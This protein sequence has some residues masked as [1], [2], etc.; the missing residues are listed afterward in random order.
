MSEDKYHAA[1]DAAAKQL[2]YRA[3]STAMLRQKLLNKGHDEQAADYALAWLSERG[4][5]SDAAYAEA[6]V[7]SYAH[8]GYG[9]Q[10]IRQE[11]TARGLDRDTAAA[12]L[13]GFAPDR[14]LLLKLLDKRL[15]GDTSDRKQVDKAVAFLQR[16]GF[17]WGQIKEALTAYAQDGAPE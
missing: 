4:L 12:A 8:R 10:R 1:L 3:L 9:A 7:R 14:A 15:K 5:L 17:S 13:E 11:L 2:S 16:R 6:V